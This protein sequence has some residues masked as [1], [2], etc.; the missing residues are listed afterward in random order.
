MLGQPQHTCSPGMRLKDCT[1]SFPDDKS[2]TVYSEQ[3][4]SIDRSVTPFALM[5]CPAMAS[6]RLYIK[7][8]LSA[9]N[10][11][12]EDSEQAGT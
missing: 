4:S 9:F 3:L 7:T 8:V 10:L 12:H 11:L 6:G 1:N 2:F 5:F